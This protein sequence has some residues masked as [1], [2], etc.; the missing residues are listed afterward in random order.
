MFRFTI[1]IANV[2][3]AP[4]QNVDIYLYFPDGFELYEEKDIPSVPE[5]PHLPEKPMSAIERLQ[6]PSF[7]FRMPNYA[8]PQTG[9]PSSFSLKRTNSYEAYD[10]FPVIKHN[11]KAC[12]PELFLQFASLDAAKAFRCDYRVTVDNLPKEIRGNINFQ[13]LPDGQDSKGD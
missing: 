8:L 1:G 5:E 12:L 3:T 6:T 9:F 2:G 11:E 4:A 13:F 10:S 7:G